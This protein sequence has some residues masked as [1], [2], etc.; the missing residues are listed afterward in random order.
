MSGART[1]PD[2]TERS[3][4]CC[5]F[6]FHVPSLFPL[7]AAFTPLKMKMFTM[8]ATGPVGI[9]AASENTKNIHIY[10]CLVCDKT[11]LPARK[12]VFV[13]RTQ[14]DVCVLA[15]TCLTRTCTLS[16][17][18]YIIH[19]RGCSLNLG[20]PLIHQIF[21]FPTGGK[22]CESKYTY[23]W[24]GAGK[25]TARRCQFH[26]SEDPT[27]ARPHLPVAATPPNNRKQ[28]SDPKPGTQAA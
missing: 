25:I 1:S 28:I 11:G 4:I 16:S 19:R 10:T 2:D 27:A 13:D 3:S 9:P 15:K 18:L 23:L 6:L 26:P 12:C 20:T 7:A 8:A 14:C 22:I 17:P 24:N 21:T 5:C